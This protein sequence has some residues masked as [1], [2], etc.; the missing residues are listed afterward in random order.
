MFKFLIVLVVC[1][2]MYYVILAAQLYKI[3]HEQQGITHNVLIQDYKYLIL[4][5]FIMAVPK[6]L[7]NEIVKIFSKPYFKHI[8]KCQEDK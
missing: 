2:L 3:L 4:G 5:P 7:F 1:L 8:A 6:Y